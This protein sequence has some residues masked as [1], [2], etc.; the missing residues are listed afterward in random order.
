MKV[1]HCSSSYLSS[2]FKLNMSLETRKEDPLRDSQKNQ[3]PYVAP[4]KT[5]GRLVAR[6][7]HGWLYTR[8]EPCSELR[9]CFEANQNLGSKSLKM[10][11]IVNEDNF[12][13][14]RRS[15]CFENHF[16]MP[17]RG[18]NYAPTVPKRTPFAYM[19]WCS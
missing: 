16:T 6:N 7:L 17:V 8:N 19:K 12:H 4:M 13:A 11:K 10:L 5:L 3:K 14:R 18:A 9:L 15:A 2:S 1:K